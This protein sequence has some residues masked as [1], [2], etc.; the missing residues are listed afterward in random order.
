MAAEP[1]EITS[2]IRHVRCIIMTISGALKPGASVLWV[3]A[4]VYAE[5]VVPGGLKYEKI[6]YL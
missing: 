2:E 6:F 1:R 5:V 3:Y 4:P